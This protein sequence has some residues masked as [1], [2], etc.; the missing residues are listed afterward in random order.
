MTD[1]T[2]D[3]DP[4]D[5]SF[6]TELVLP[7]FALSTAFYAERA[8]GSILLLKRAEGTAMAGVYFLPGGLVDPG[9]EPFEAAVREL[10]EESGLE[11]L[12]GPTMVGCYPMWVYGRDMLQLSFRGRVAGD[13][14]AIVSSEHTDHRWVQP[15]EF[16]AG[17]TPDA[18]TSLA[19]GNDRIAAL[20]SNIGN[21]VDRYLRLRGRPDAPG[22]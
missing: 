5:P 11:L 16:A 3:T 20:L 14:E 6:E 17:F 15:E 21:D 12:E 1:Q 8:D 4:L 18:V 10:R 19:G 13:G 2:P 7:T 22:M 9:E